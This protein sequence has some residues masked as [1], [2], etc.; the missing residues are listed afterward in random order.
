VSLRL[1]VA[2]ELPPDAKDGILTVIEDLRARGI[3]AS[4]SREGTLHLTLAFLG[5]TDEDDVDA[6][7]GA[8]ATAAA[9]VPPFRWTVRGLGAFP[10]PRRPRVVWA[11]VEAPEALFDLKQRID[12][13][14]RPL[15]FKPDRR[16]FR[17]H[18]TLGRIRREGDAPALGRHIASLDVPECTVPSNEVILMKSTLRKG[19]ALH[20]ALERFPLTGRDGALRE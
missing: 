16:R 3:R 12:T 10:S 17:P 2:L 11:G 19:G 7:A 5:D 14:L 18:I 15:G 9:G 13:E 20:E 8:L 4:W 1:F 6:V